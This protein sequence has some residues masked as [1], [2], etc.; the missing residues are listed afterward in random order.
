[1]HPRKGADTALML[2][3]AKLM[4]ANA[5]RFVSEQDS[6]NASILG[7]DATPDTPEFDLFQ[8]V[9]LSRFRP[10]PSPELLPHWQ[11]SPSPSTPSV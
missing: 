2:R 11:L 3:S 8:V 5:T 10:T 9:S 1:M 7:P 6:L 4:L